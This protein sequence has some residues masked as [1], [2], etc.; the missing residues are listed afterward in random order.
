M[1]WKIMQSSSL[2]LPGSR[3]N[4]AERLSEFRAGKVSQEEKEN[5]PNRAG[6]VL[7]ILIILFTALRRNPFEIN[8]VL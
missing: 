8:Y 2:K 6:F 3:R 1:C 4:G 7:E 5:E